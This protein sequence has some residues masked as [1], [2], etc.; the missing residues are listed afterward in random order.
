MCLKRGMARELAC[1]MMKNMMHHGIGGYILMFRQ[2]HG[3]RPP[4]WT[5]LI[6]LIAPLGTLTGYD[7]CCAQLFRWSQLMKVFIVFYRNYNGDMIMHHL[8]HH[9]AACSA[10]FL[11]VQGFGRVQCS[12]QCMRL[13]PSVA[14]CPA[15]CV[16]LHGRRWGLTVWYDVGFYQKP[17]QE[18]L[19]LIYKLVDHI[20]PH[21]G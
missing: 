4:R 12:D 21:V 2:S 11:G 8:Y 9:S 6:H 13:C 19:G 7:G 18:I 10:F 16:S 3:L 20:W 5:V 1:L 15:P 17:L 14:L